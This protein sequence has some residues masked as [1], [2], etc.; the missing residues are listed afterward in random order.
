MTF[1]N[2]WDEVIVHVWSTHY[3]RD[4]V[5]TGCRDPEDGEAYSLFRRDTGEREGV[6]AGSLRW[7]ILSCESKYEIK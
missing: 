7:A 3:L 5:A 6:Y 2:K 1:I 4:D